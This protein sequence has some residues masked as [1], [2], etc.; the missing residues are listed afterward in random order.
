M[1]LPSVMTLVLQ[2]SFL[3]EN[4]GRHSGLF[5]ERGV[6][7]RFGTESTVIGNRLKG[8]L[9]VSRVAQAFFNLLNA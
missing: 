3:Q 8:K 2:L 4:S 5:S 1:K 6:K 9:L 7:G